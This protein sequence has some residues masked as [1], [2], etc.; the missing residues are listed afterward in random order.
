MVSIIAINNSLKDQSFVCTQLNDQTV[1]FQA[2]QFCISHLV[3][4]V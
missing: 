3:A 1:L 4:L 2:I